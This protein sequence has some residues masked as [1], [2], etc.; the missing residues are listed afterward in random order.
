VSDSVVPLVLVAR[1]TSGVLLLLYWQQCHVGSSAWVGL[2][3]VRIHSRSEFHYGCDI[4]KKF[5]EPLF[6]SSWIV[7]SEGVEWARRLLPERREVLCLCLTMSWDFILKGCVSFDMKCITLHIGGL[8]ALWPYARDVGRLV[9]LLCLWRCFSV[10]ALW[11]RLRC[12]YTFVRI[13][14]SIEWRWGL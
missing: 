14:V 10:S 3:P 2:R 9:R 8:S 11:R 7:D 4:W 1:M 12:L 6:S 5:L 13:I